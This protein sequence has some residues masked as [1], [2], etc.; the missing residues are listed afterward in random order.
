MQEKTIREKKREL[1]LLAKQTGNMPTLLYA[2]NKM[3]DFCVKDRLN[4]TDKEDVIK[5]LHKA[6]VEVKPYSRQQK[7]ME[8]FVHDNFIHIMNNWKEYR[9]NHVTN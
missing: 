8:D 2:F 6:I 9:Q 5:L 1:I 7:T 4:W 3:I